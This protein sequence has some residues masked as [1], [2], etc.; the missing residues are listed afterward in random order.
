MRTSLRHFLLALAC[1]LAVAGV[2][3]ASSA[4]SVRLGYTFTPIAF[5]GHQTATWPWNVNT[6]GVVI[7]EYW[8]G[9]PNDAQNGSQALGFV[10][11]F[12]H[13]VT[14]K[15]PNMGPYDEMNAM[16]LT[17]SG[18]VI[19]GYY[20]GGSVSTAG[21]N[22][23]IYIDRHG[24]FTNLNDPNA[25]ASCTTGQCGTW[26][27]SA[28]FWGEVVGSYVGTD[29]VWHGFIYQH[30]HWT[31]VDNPGCGAGNATQFTGVG[32]QGMMAG[33]CVSDGGN[34]NQVS[35]FL[36]TAHGQSLTFP[37]LTAQQ[38]PGILPNSP[39]EWGD[40]TELWGVNDHGLR[41]GRY[42]AAAPTQ[43]CSDLGLTINGFVE[44]NDR[45]TPIIVPSK[46]IHLPDISNP[47]TCVMNMYGANEAGQIAGQY[48]DTSTQYGESYG[49][50]VNT[51][52]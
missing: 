30:G 9:A 41:D 42:F 25:V 47:N 29:G 52:F 43:D 27:L 50:V 51:G 11:H 19:G 35:N 40:S 20:Y 36:Y 46:T 18:E 28:N 17:Q 22:G 33:Q 32:D 49:F 38:A 23:R 14:I 39:T 7:G 48:W 2:S 13:Y 31:T 1:A 5:P 8:T 12:G 4:G 6:E 26:P 3:T 15:E 24:H 16:E 10:D 21:S 45:V 44:Q 37:D 34:G